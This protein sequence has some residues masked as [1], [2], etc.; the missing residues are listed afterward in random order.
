MNTHEKGKIGEDL[1]AEYLLG[2]GYTVETRNYRTRRGELDIVAI[3]PD[4]TLVFVEVKAAASGACGNPLYK[5]TPAKQKTLQYMARRYM[6][7]RK[8]TNRACRMDVIGVWRGKIDHIQNA[9]FAF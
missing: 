6:Y 1:A 9:F 4:G 2:Q 3:A 8:I 5:V 7:E